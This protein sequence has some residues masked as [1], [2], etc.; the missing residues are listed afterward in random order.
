MQFAYDVAATS[1][2]EAQE[3][4]KRGYDLKS[5]GAVVEVSDRVLV[6]NVGLRGKHKLAD[7]WTQEVYIVHRQPNKDIPVFE[8]KREDGKGAVRTLHRNMLLPITSV[9]PADPT[10]NRRVKVPERRL[11]A[12]GEDELVSDDSDGEEVAVLLQVAPP[13]PG[14]QIPQVDGDL[15]GNGAVI[16]NGGGAD[17]VDIV[18]NNE[19][20][21]PD[22]VVEGE[23]QAVIPDDVVEGWDE[24]VIPDD[25]VEGEDQVVVPDDVVEGWDE[26]VVADD[27]VEGWDEAVIPGDVVEGWDEAVIRDDVVEGEDEAV[28]PDDAGIDVPAPGVE[29]LADDPVSEGSENGDDQ[30]DEESESEAS[31]PP[32]RPQRNRAL[33][34]KLR[35]DYILYAQHVHLRKLR[36]NSGFSEQWI[37]DS[38]ETG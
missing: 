17:P 33:P 3:H 21:I 36:K 22:D 4:Q 38:L 2:K 14:V 11:G 8:V 27:V 34:T 26:A 15:D 32:R 1:I 13:R 18:E 35:K 5:R 9:L 25:V 6:R 12:V 23:D 7:R 24:A 37:L 30:S 29:L 16:L 20:V 31:P 19:A 10:E 28:H